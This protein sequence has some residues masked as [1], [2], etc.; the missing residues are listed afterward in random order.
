M[1]FSVGV[2]KNCLLVHWTLKS[3][4]SRERIYRSNSLKVFLGKDFLKIYSKFTGEHPCPSVTSIKLQSNFIKITLQHGCSP[5]NFATYFQNNVFQN[6]SG[7]LPLNLWM[8]NVV[9]SDS[10]NKIH[11]GWYV[12]CNNLITLVWS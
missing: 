3:A 12:A 5:V 10:A 8:L 9:K 1:I 11:Q 4:A 7:G 2:I 6:I